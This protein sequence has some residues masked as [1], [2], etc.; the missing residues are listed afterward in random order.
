LEPLAG[1]IGVSVIELLRGER[2]DPANDLEVREAVRIA[3]AEFK[4]HFHRF[5]RF[6]KACIALFLVLVIGWKTYE[7]L[8]TGGDGFDPIENA[9]V[10]RQG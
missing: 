6:M 7:F 9:R 3:G 2:C 1:A 8:K 4:I 10:V 5:Q